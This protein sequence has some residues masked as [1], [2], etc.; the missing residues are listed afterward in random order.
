MSERSLLSSDKE[1]KAETV[2]D[3]TLAKEGTIERIYKF[4]A[5]QQ[6]AFMYFE[7]IE[8]IARSKRV[9]KGTPDRAAKRKHE[10]AEEIRIKQVEELNKRYR[11]ICK[12]MA[13]YVTD[14]MTNTQKDSLFDVSYFFMDIVDTLS[15]FKLNIADREKFSKGLIDFIGQF[16]ES[17]PEQ[18]ASGE[19]I[20]E[21]P[22]PE[23][24]VKAEEPN[25]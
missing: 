20:E 21:V 11:K 4:Y 19:H 14:G 3:A 5:F 6:G 7:T 25:A 12:D 23:A 16:I 9:L 22:T 13:H 10:K 8:A 15:L 24:E 1:N 2:V 17:N 18:A